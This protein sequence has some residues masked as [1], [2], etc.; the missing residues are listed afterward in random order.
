[1]AIMGVISGLLTALIALLFRLAV[2]LPLETLLPAGSESFESLPH[3]LRFALP[4]AGAVLIGL[5][6]HFSD[7]NYREGSVRHVIDRLQYHQGYLPRG[8]ALMQFFSAAIALLSGASVGREGPAVHLGAASSSQLGKSLKLPNNSL[9]ILVGC[10]VAGAIS[11]SFNTP[12]AGVIFAMEVVLME[13]TI[14]GFIPVILASV[15]G[16]VLSRLA[17]GDEPAFSIPV[18]QTGSLLELPL[19]IITGLFI[20]LLAALTLKLYQ[21]TTKKQSWPILLR[22]VLVGLLT[23]VFAMAVPQI[24]GIGYD[25]LEQAMLGQLGLGILS[26][27][28]IAKLIASTVTVGLGM[29]GGIIGPSLVIGA[30]AGSL[31]GS[32]GNQFYPGDSTHAGFYAILGMGAMM[33]AVLNAPLAALMAI[34]EMTYNP[35]ILMPGMLTIVVATITARMT[36]DLPGIFSIGRDRSDYTS[37]VFQMLSRAGVTSLM[38]KDFA[39][40]SRHITPEKARQLLDEKPRW[41]LVEDLGE[42]KYILRPADLALYMEQEDFT[43]PDRDETI[44]LHKIP[45]ERSLLL[46]IHREATLLEALLKMKQHNGRADRTLLPLEK[47]YLW[48]A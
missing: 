12:L 1:M 3:Q 37:P 39:R 29:P 7:P 17:F 21:N 46:P 43:D 30:C 24:M 4:L 6:F 27:I 40:H 33:G 36:S 47:P 38:A 26:V 32:L 23:G 20:G 31:I 35:H 10:G 16:A 8:N 48:E 28:V 14:V 5:I 18:I 11:A 9:R 42:E 22:A 2:D 41:L 44:D 15:S 25:T 45:A 19:A 13:Y 34:M